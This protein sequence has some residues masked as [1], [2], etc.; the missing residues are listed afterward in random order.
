MKT[1]LLQRRRG[2][3]QI[4]NVQT[5]QAYSYRERE[6]LLPAAVDAIVR[7]GGWVLDR[8]NIS[9]ITLCFQLEIEL[10]S[11]FDLYA[12]LLAVGME[13][14]RSGHRA[15]AG[16][17]TCGRYAQKSELHQVL[18]MQ[19]EISFLHEIAPQW[20]LMAHPARA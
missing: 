8:S 7:C 19:L 6:D 18:Q 16:L 14:T 3:M 4:Q 2:L 5:I 1:Y 9:E 11:V 10:R 15:L 12:A 20:L 13:M 17:C